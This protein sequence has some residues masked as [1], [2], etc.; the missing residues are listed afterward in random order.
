[1]ADDTSADGTRTAPQQW[2]LY[3]RPFSRITLGTAPALCVAS[4]EYP[5]ERR[6]TRP[7][8]GNRSPRSHPERATWRRHHRAMLMLC[9]IESGVR[10]SNARCVRV[11][12]Q[13]LS[14]NLGESLSQPPTRIIRRATYSPPRTLLFVDPSRA[15]RR[16][17][18]I[19]RA[20]AS[21]S[22]VALSAPSGCFKQRWYARRPWMSFSAPIETD[23]PR[24]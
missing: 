16:V 23:Q 3:L 7:P 2:L 17:I 21:L 20:T 22:R 24:T 5:Y 15:Q 9:L 19:C 11:P 18:L 1:M 4:D 6:D 10:C 14:R 12:V 8:Q 13:H